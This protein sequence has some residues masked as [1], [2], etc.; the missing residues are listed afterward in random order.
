[1]N[2]K[3]NKVANAIGMKNTRWG[4]LTIIMFGIWTTLTCL[5]CFMKYDFLN[6]TMG[7]VGLFMLLDPQQIK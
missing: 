5:T 1:M 7:L 2:V 3:F 6:L 4:R